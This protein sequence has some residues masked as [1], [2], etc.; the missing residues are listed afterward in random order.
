MRPFAVPW[1]SAVL[2]V[3]LIAPLFA[4][5]G[6]SGGA[7]DRV[8][9]AIDRLAAGGVGVYDS[10]SAAAPTR[11]ASG[12]PSAMRLTRWQLAN[13]LAQAQAGMG[14][15]GSTLDALA[16][17]DVP[18]G[19]P[20]MSAFVAAWLQRGTG[21]L[22]PYAKTF[23]PA[24]A[25][26]AKPSSLTY[27]LL[28]VVLFVADAARP[29]AT[30]AATAKADPFAFERLIAAPAQADGICSTV[31]GFISQTVADVTNALKV[32]GDGFFATLWNTT[33][34]LVGGAA[35]GIAKVAIGGIIYPL[36]AILTKVAGVLAAIT[37]I[38]STLQPWSVKVDGDPASVTLGDQPADG[39]VVATLDAPSIDWPSQ[40][41]DCAQA[42]GDV[43]LASISFKDAPVKWHTMNGFPQYAT[44]TDQDPTIHPDKTATL[45]YATV[46]RQIENVQCAS[47]HAVGSLF[48]D[49]TVERIDALH[50]QQQLTGI[51]FGMLPQV[52]RENLQPVFQPL[53]DAGT[54][55]LS[56]V[57]QEPADGNAII[58]VS[59]LEADPLKCTPAPSAAPPAAL[60]PPAK[61][62]PLANTAWN[63]VAT[64]H[65]HV[66]EIPD[67]PVQMKM[68]V[69]FTDTA[70]TGMTASGLS[71]EGGVVGNNVGKS[72][73]GSVPYTYEPTGDQGGVLHMA[74][75]NPDVPVAFKSD[76]TAL[77]MKFAPL[78]VGPASNPNARGHWDGVLDCKK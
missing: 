37:A 21:E 18:K 68:H 63:C 13:L 45:H 34:D 71:M 5:A 52:V 76:K 12:A 28:V 15:R 65:V 46:A 8:A 70:V 9:P 72:E 73:G 53:L 67:V 17:P 33:V 7:A 42:L 24:N 78:D 31:S 19:A 23:M 50:A 69:S 61:E 2:F 60:P 35:L 75:K 66:P 48:V 26:Y 20:A 43:D 29:S 10:Y 25:E 49:A 57:L 77:V 1:V 39:K 4:L 54:K 59:Q 40:V 74:G 6:C 36:T 27:P 32:S 11:A 47:P 14:F 3:A 64:A 16:G 44:V 58:V 41:T 56:E 51:V 55:K 22:A 38:S 62:N 30:A